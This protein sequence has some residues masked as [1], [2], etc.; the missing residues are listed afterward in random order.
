[1]ENIIS[2]AAD[3]APVIMDD[4]P[5]MLLVLIHRHNLV[6]KKVSPFLSETLNQ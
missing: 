1:M 2:C 4:N 6:S 3:G 5:Q